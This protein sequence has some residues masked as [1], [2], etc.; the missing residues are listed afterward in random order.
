MSMSP[1]GYLQFAATKRP[2]AN[3]FSESHLMGREFYRYFG[4]LQLPSTKLP[5]ISSVSR[6][7]VFPTS[8]GKFNKYSFSWV[9]KRGRPHYGHAVLLACSEPT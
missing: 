3:I 1:F 6:K 8:H 7:V 9:R 5:C 4:V 2:W